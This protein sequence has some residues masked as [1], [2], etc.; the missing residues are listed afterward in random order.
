M[1]PCNTANIAEFESV[2]SYYKTVIGN[3]MKLGIVM[4]ETIFV[5]NIIIYTC[6]QHSKV[7]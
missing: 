5:I 6:L 1:G 4:Y 2:C 3:L 7:L